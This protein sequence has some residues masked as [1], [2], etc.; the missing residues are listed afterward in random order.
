[1]IC[2]CGGSVG[3]SASRSVFVRAERRFRRMLRIGLQAVKAEAVEGVL[4][5]LVA[6]T[7]GGRQSRRILKIRRVSDFQSWRELAQCA[8]RKSVRSFLT[9]MPCNEQCID[10]DRGMMRD[11][12]AFVTGSRRPTPPSRAEQDAM[13]REWSGRGCGVFS[14]LERKWWFAFIVDEVNGEVHF[15]SGARRLREGGGWS[16]G[17]S[18]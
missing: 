6:C 4:P 2:M 5:V 12:I 7:I 1:V 14:T 16:I 8:D 10:L 11:S 13:N 9:A 17:C 18:F 15:E 3:V